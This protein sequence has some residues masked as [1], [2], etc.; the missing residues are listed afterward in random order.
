M[1]S[2]KGWIFLDWLRDYQLLEK[3]SAP[4]YIYIDRYI[5]R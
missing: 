3:G 4:I 2:I 5:D 1:G